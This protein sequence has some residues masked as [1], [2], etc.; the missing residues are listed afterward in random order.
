M[1]LISVIIPVYNV[2]N[3]LKK[4][5]DSVISQTYNNLDIIL[6][7]D[8][9]KDYSGK[10]CEEYASKDKRITLISRKNAGQAS[11]RNIGLDMAKGEFI[12]F[13]DSD[14]YIEPNMYEILLK[15]LTESNADIAECKS[16]NF[17]GNNF[18]NIVQSGKITILSQEEVLNDL[19]YNKYVR[20]E[21]WDKLYRKSSIGEVRFKDGQLFEEVYFGR[22]VF[23]KINSLVS[24]DMV[25]YNYLVGRTGNTNSTFKRSRLCVFEEL[26][27][28]ASD[29]EK[30]G[31]YKCASMLS[32]IEM[33]F[34]MFL[35]WQ[36]DIF[37]DKESKKYIKQTFLKLHNAN[38]K[39]IY[40][41][42]KAVFIFKNLF[43]IYKAFKKIKER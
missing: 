40:I 29:M 15:A 33:N 5:L 34:C 3:Y 7:N 16:R 31:N 6:I 35:Y 1:E 12:A 19:F 14:D 24:V 41:N 36:A 42:K 18:S 30:K 38:K 21:V 11:A 25:L 39:N 20:F 27:L 4:C 37:K 26:E 43:F 28:F 13:V 10:I 17:F 2:E 9:S 23:Q 22:L 8:G 32:A